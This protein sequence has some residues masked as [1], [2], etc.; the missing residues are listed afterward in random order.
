MNG[1]EMSQAITNA[2]LEARKEAAQRCYEL[3]LLI[4]ATPQL[5]HHQAAERYGAERVARRI[6][7]E[8]GIQEKGGE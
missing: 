3:A 1:W 5:R 2:I 6:A 8:F 4:V 7:K